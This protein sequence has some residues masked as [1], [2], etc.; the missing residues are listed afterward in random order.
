MIRLAT[1]QRLSGATV[2]H[3]LTSLESSL[4]P[5]DAASVDSPNTTAETIT[6]KLSAA[7]TAIPPRQSKHEPVYR[8]ALTGTVQ[9][10]LLI[11]PVMAEWRRLKPGPRRHTNGLHRSARIRKVDVPRMVEP[12]RCKRG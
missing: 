7:S 2:R 5:L 3:L 4:R 1:N 11:G 9:A 6:N 10:L 12:R 8:I